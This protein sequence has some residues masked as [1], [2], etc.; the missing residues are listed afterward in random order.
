MYKH[1]LSEESCVIKHF[2]N[3]V[4]PEETVI[5]NEKFIPF[6]IGKRQCPGESLAK[7]EIFLYLVGG[8]IN[9]TGGAPGSWQLTESIRSQWLAIGPI[10]WIA[11]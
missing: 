4:G 9:F 7:A 8:N 3:I 10:Q 11:A 6:L 2:L 5:S 1:F